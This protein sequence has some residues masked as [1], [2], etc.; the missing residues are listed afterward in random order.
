MSKVYGYCKTDKSAIITLNPKLL[1]NGEKI[2]ERIKNNIMSKH[3]AGVQTKFA[4]YSNNH[5]EAK[6]RLETIAESI[7]SME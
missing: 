7:G 2:L 6:N 3:S 4:E 1:N 5:K